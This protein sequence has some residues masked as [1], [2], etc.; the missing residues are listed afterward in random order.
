MK[1]LLNSIYS[2]ASRWLFSTN[3]KDI[4]MLYIVFGCLFGILGTTVSILI[5]M[6]LAQSY[7]VLIFL[8]SLMIFVL[9]KRLI[10]MNS[11]IDFLH[12]FLAIF[13][14]C[15][16]IIFLLLLL[17]PISFCDEIAPVTNGDWFCPQTWNMIC[18]VTLGCVVVSGVALAGYGL[19]CFCGSSYGT[20]C[21]ATVFGT[22]STSAALNIPT[23][24]QSDDIVTKKIIDVSKSVVQFV[25]PT[26][27]NILH[28]TSLE[29]WEI[30]LKGYSSIDYVV[31]AKSILSKVD[32][33][34]FFN[35]TIVDVNQIINYI[36]ITGLPLLE[37]TVNTRRADLIAYN[38][39]L[40]SLPPELINQC[41][42]NLRQCT[43][44]YSYRVIE[45]SS[46]P[47][48]IITDNSVEGLMQ[49]I[50]N[51]SIF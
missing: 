37:T 18:N 45:R 19:F 27:S 44:E 4:G 46:G 8:L 48:P 33:N 47:L 51:M 32:I 43:L 39:S 49:F 12:S 23:N 36:Y 14:Y 9:V 25:D 21:Y 34:V 1:I 28:T 3:C 13:R 22:S 31:G 15:L 50:A 7:N 11:T 16:L 10:F 42:E 26:T 20:A 38:K 29:S 40:D 30:A 41:I 24:S 2:F 35:W 6:E 17:S 5:R